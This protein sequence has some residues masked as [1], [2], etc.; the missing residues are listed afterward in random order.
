MLSWISCAS[1]PLHWREIQARH[2]IN[3]D[4]G[5]QTNAEWCM[6]FSPK[7]LC[8]CFVDVTG[9]GKESEKLVHIVHRTAAE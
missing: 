6:T 4:V 3:P 8:G 2:M 9:I 7:E 1:R 5:P